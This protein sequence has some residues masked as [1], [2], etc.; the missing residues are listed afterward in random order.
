ERREEAA[1]ADTLDLDAETA[2][3]LDISPSAALGRSSSTEL[4]PHDAGLSPDL[5]K[6]VREAVMSRASEILINIRGEKIQMRQRLRGIYVPMEP[7]K[8]GLYLHQVERLVAWLKKVGDKES[9]EGVE[10]T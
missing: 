6:L 4:A 1:A 3:L 2:A 9:A 8:D 5:M 7:G 10:W